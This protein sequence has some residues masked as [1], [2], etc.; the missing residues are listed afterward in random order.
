MDKNS[1]MNCL[2][3]TPLRY[4]NII[5]VNKNRTLLELKQK[6][7]KTHEEIADTAGVKYDSVVKF[8]REPSG[9]GAEVAY[10]VSTAMG[11]SQE[12]AK[13]FWLSCRQDHKKALDSANWDRQVK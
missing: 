5:M 13:Q 11:M 9:V 12:D 8:I 6:I 7:G 3:K 1:I 2:T 4:N 10:K